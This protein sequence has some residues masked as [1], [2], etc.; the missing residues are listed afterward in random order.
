V[1]VY[2][3]VYMSVHVRVRV[4]LCG[5]MLVSACVRVRVRAR[6][7]VPTHQ[8]EVEVAGRDV[9]VAARA[10]VCL[11]EYMLARAARTCAAVVRAR[12]Q[13]PP[14]PTHPGFCAV[15]RA[16]EDTYILTRTRTR[17]RTHTLPPTISPTYRRGRGQGRLHTDEDAHLRRP[18]VSLRGGAAS[19]PQPAATTP[20]VSWGLRGPI[21]RRTAQD[22]AARRRG[23]GGGAV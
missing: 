2:A 17:A 4:T 8:A 16:G 12:N 10:G 19:A 13:T 18:S 6:A 1:C 22:T 20:L 21:R 11:R 14:G 15:L 7:R 3:C 23:G 5:C 9:V